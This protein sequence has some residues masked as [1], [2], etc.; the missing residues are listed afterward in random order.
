MVVVVRKNLAIASL[1]CVTQM[2]SVGLGIAWGLAPAH[3]VRW[4]LGRWALYGTVALLLLGFQLL[5]SLVT[6]RSRRGSAITSWACT[7]LAAYA[8]SLMFFDPFLRVPGDGTFVVG[9]L[10]L[11]P[12]V[13]AQNVLARSGAWFGVAGSGLFLATSL[14]MLIRNGLL[15]SAG[16]G[17]FGR[18]V[19]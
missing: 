12:F 13:L 15:V 8:A 10:L 9:V 14:G 19:T 7:A 11:L 18:W 5:H 1:V 17:F 3:G 16:T 6:L 4:L 2:A